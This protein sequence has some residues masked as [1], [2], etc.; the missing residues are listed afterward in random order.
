MHAV[1]ASYNPSFE[2]LYYIYMQGRIH[3]FRLGRGRTV[4]ISQKKF[5]RLNF[6]SKIDILCGK[7]SK[8]LKFQPK[9]A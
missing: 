6:G 2:V 3:D 5:L 1:K 4:K 7:I 9:I 8:K